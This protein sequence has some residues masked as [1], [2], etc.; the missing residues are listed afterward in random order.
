MVSFMPSWNVHEKYCRLM[1]I[2]I[3]VCRDVNKLVDD[4]RWHDFF[5][6]MLSR[7]ETPVL[8][9]LGGRIVM[10]NFY[11]STLYTNQQL[12]KWLEERGEDA[13]KAF[14]LHMFLDLIERN[15]RSGKG[16]AMLI[17]NDI[18]GLYREYVEGI[19]DFIN[20]KIDEIMKDIAAYIQ[21]KKNRRRH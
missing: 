17:V 9:V 7:S 15:M 2:S 10:Y 14:F 11:S 16:F 6:G 1:G 8:R 13:F 19:E 18:H 4:V 5:D 20:S 3:D 12:R 21:S